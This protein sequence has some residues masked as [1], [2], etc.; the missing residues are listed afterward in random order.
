VK[1]FQWPRKHT[2]Q[3]G[4]NSSYPPP[5]CHPVAG[6]PDFC[7]YSEVGNYRYDQTPSFPRRRESMGR[8]LLDSR[9]RGNDGIHCLVAN[10]T[11]CCISFSVSFRGFRGQMVLCL[12]M[13]PQATRRLVEYAVDEL[14]GLFRA[15]LLGQ[16]H[17][18]VDHHPVGDVRPRLQFIAGQAQHGPL[19]GI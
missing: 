4:K 14:V 16:V 3:H 19:H 8:K 5:A 15:E 10:M 11:D 6:F 13:G 12:F 7:N 9:L 1:R 2:E 17:R 18:L